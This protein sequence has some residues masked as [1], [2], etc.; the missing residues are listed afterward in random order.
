MDNNIIVM[1]MREGWNAS[2]SYYRLLQYKDRISK[3]LDK[4]VVVRILVGDHIASMR[5]DVSGGNVSLIKRISSKV[6][7]NL[8]VY[9]HGI[10]Y[11]TKDLFNPPKCII[12]LRSMYP[13]YCGFPVKQL[14]L[15]LLSVCRGVVWDFDD[16]IFDNREITLT[17][18]KMLLTAADKIMLTHEGLRDLLPASQR[19]KVMLVPTTDGDVNG[20]LGQLNEVRL[21]RYDTEIRLVWVASS[22]SLPFLEHVAETLDEAALA[23]RIQLGKRLELHVVCNM[24][25]EHDFK[26]LETKFIKWERNVALRELEEAHIGIM[27]IDATRFARG[28]GGFKIVQYMAAGLPSVASAVGFNNEVVVDGRTGFLASTP[29]HWIE[30]ILRLSKN[31]SYWNTISHNARERW[32]ERF[33]YNENATSIAKAITEAISHE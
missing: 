14:Y 1:Y 18:S 21:H 12:I 29:S 7:Y 8:S 23:V 9:L 11:M 10:A 24:P 4:K 28:K 31:P 2:S 19:S 26:Y 22:S 17:E 5:S 30:G 25:L 15:K 32:D 16:D 27:P 13:K 20:N 6:L 3:E 33:S